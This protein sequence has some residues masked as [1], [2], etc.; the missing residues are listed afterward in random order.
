M[1]SAILRAMAT[2]GWFVIRV[3]LFF[4]FLFFYTQ[5]AVYLEPSAATQVATVACCKITHRS[6]NLTPPQ[7]HRGKSTSE[8]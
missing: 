4:L 3:S 1:A 6:F 8:K 7:T 2:N 5:P